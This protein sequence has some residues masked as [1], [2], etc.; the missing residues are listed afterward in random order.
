METNLTP[1]ESAHNALMQPPVDAEGNITTSLVATPS[2]ARGLFKALWDADAPQRQQRAM[3]QGMIGGIP[4][5]NPSKMQQAGLSGCTNINWRDGTLALQQAEAPYVDLVNSVPY[6]LNIV[7]EHRY[8]S[9]TERMEWERIMSNEY[10]IMMRSW[11]SFTDRFLLIVN[12]F[13]AHGV[14]MA[15]WN[16]SVDWRFHPSNLGEFVFPRLVTSDV[17]AIPLACMRREYPCAELYSFIKNATPEERKGYFN[18]W[19]C[20]TVIQA[21]KQAAPKPFYRTNDWELNEKIWKSSELYWYLSE[22]VCPCVIEWIREVDGTVTQYIVP[23][24]PLQQQQGNGEDEFLY[25]EK[26]RFGSMAEAFVVFKYGVGDNGQLHAIRGLGNAIQ[27]IVQQVNQMLCRQMDAVNVELSIP[28]QADEDVLNDQLAYQLA[29]PFLIIQEGV[30]MLE[31]HNPNYS[32]SAFPLSNMLM[33]KLNEQKGMFAGE[34][35]ANSVSSETT[36]FAFQALMEQGQGLRVSQ[37]NLFYGSFE[38]TLK[39]CLRRAVNVESA[40]EPG[41]PEAYRFKK[42]CMEQGVPAE[43]FKFID[44]PRCTVVRAIGN[45]SPGARMVALERM[46]KVVPQFD[47]EGRRHWVQDYITANPGFTYD[48]AYRYMPQVPGLR[49]DQQVRNADDENE[50]MELLRPRPI[51]PN[52]DHLVHA[53]QHLVPMNRMVQEVEMGQLE[54]T[55]AVQ[56]L[57]LLYQHTFEHLQM[58]GNDPIMQREINQYRKEMQQVAEIVV[59]GS[60]KI[61]A[62]Q[63]RAMEEGGEYGGPEGLDPKQVLEIEQQKAVLY[64]QIQ[65]SQFADARNMIQLQKLQD[66]LELN[67]REREAKLIRD[68]TMTAV[69]LADST[70]KMRQQKRGSTRKNA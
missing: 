21:I 65:D 31:R 1:P 24:N 4:P 10:G 48:M 6:F 61:Q 15:Y 51:Y 23:E 18:G 32:N 7:L 22:I 12:Y 56:P 14:S 25:E 66:E 33:Q 19:H 35:T 68:D 8:A 44:L 3:V 20:P 38:C 29:G 11:E 40:L 16:D 46:E 41:G 13:L 60:R 43:A 36:K 5:W 26:N 63:Q 59:N 53:R 45:G 28:I 34:G 17:S 30:K 42:R 39:E 67:R 70:A 64:R 58:L 49:P 37:A 54:M 9:I 57:S 47:E 50:F 2:D 69:K 52:D 62:E 27:P 55:E